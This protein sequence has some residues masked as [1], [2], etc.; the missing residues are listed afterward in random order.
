MK[1]HLMRFNIIGDNRKEIPIN[2]LIDKISV[3]F[4]FLIRDFKILSAF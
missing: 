3:C 4:C 1:I 2:K